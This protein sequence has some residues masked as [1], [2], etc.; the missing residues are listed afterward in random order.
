MEL[1]HAEE[2]DYS[3]IICTY[4]PDREV[5]RRC[6]RAV[7]GLDRTGLSTETIVVDNNSSPA[8]D[9]GG[10][11][12]AAGVGIPGLRLLREP[13][14]GVV[15]ARITAIRASRGKTIIYIDDD[16][17]PESDYL[18]ALRALEPQFPQV[19]AWGPGHVT[20]EYTDGI[21][22]T[23]ESMA[24]QF[25]QERHETTTRFDNKLEW[26]DCYPFGTGMCI[27]REI[28]LRYL[29]MADAGSVTMEG[30][31][32]RKLTSGEDTQMV[33]VGLRDGHAAG[34]S[35]VLRLRHLIPARK[36][37]T[38]YLKRL[39]YGTSICYETCLLQ[40]FP[41]REAGLGARIMPPAKFNRKA[42]KKWVRAGFGLHRR[43][44]FELGSYIGLQEGIYIAAGRPVPVF[45]NWIT[46]WLQFR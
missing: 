46:R 12:T 32:A 3:I 27:R 21:D 11:H 1:N 6:L 18:Q 16:N 39:V 17:E 31:T 19:G 14:P 36:A 40:V 42:F 34:V 13:Q 9:E 43:K 23:L 20:V 37:Q 45:V 5:F 41:E 29:E 30:R 7:A 35:P 26:Q 8:L 33:L 44:T 2:V 22:P 38:A 10:L 15:R 25:F 28:L 4:N 24:T